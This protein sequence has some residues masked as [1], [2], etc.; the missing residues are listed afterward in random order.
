MQR[1]HVVVVVFVG[2][3]LRSRFRDSLVARFIISDALLHSRLIAIRYCGCICFRFHCLGSRRY[4]FDI[5]IVT[6]IVVS[7]CH[8]F[9]CFL[10]AG[11][12]CG[13]LIFT[14]IFVC[15]TITSAFSGRLFGLRVVSYSDSVVVC[16]LFFLFAR[17]GFFRCTL[18]RFCHYGWCR[19]LA[20]AALLGCLLCAIIGSINSIDRGLLFCGG[21]HPLECNF[22]FFFFSHCWPCFTQRL[23]IH[24]GRRL[25]D[26]FF[27]VVIIL[28]FLAIV[29]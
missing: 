22:F 8:I 18:L 5:V 16:F 29:C 1:F 14:S 2:F 20:F 10:L 19:F 9:A 11:F 27:V 25:G 13:Q 7:V 4:L 24:D 17:S 12:P 26:F 23:L 28:F 3:V 21:C 15:V 6:A